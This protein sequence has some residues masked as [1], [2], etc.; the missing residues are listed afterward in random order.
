MILSGHRPDEYTTVDIAMVAA[1]RRTQ[2]FFSTATKNYSNVLPNVVAFSL[3]VI[4]RV[5]RFVSPER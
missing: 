1:G 2:C 3:F 5:V 4:S